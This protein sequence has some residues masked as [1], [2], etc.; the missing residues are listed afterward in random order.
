MRNRTSDLRI[1]RSDA[2]P[3]SQRDSMALYEVHVFINMTLWT[4][5]TIAVCRTRV[6]HELS[7]GYSPWSLCG[8]VVEQSEGLRFDFSWGLR[9]FFF[10]PRSCQDENIFSPS[11]SAQ[12]LYTRAR[13]HRLLEIDLCNEAQKSLAQDFSTSFDSVY[14]PGKTTWDCNQKQKN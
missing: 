5:P 6:I 12:A 7:D 3:P 8:S 14:D 4:S 11:T 13:G 2:L 9:I 1:P 10:V